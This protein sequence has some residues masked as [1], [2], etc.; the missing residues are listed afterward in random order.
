MNNAPY[1]LFYRYGQC[2]MGGLLLAEADEHLHAILLGDDE[3]SL[4]ADLQAR[5]P[6]ALLQE[7]DSSLDQTLQAAIGYVDQP[8]GR[9]PVSKPLR[10]RGTALQ[11]EV[12]HALSEVPAGSTISYAELARRIGRPRAVRAVAAACAAN[13][14]AIVVPCHRVLRSDGEVSGYRWGVERKRQLLAREREL[15]AVIA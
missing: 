11:C 3:Q 13:P 4:L 9:F 2:S 8:Q 5:F 15:A 10:L 14:L 1:P 12:W 6:A 7:G